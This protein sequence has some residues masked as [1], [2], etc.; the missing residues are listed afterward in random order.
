MFDTPTFQ[1]D[2]AEAARYR[3][4]SEP[5]PTLRERMASVLVKLSHRG[6]DVLAADLER[7]GFKASEI[8]AH[9]PAASVLADEQLTRDVRRDIEGYDRE[10]RIRT[11]A[12]IVRGLMPDP[13]MIYTTLRHAG[14]ETL[15]VGD[16][17]PDIIA[18]AADEFDAS[19]APR[20]GQRAA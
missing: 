12:L 19:L 9:L 1:S 6:R 15:E 14:F 20:P 8:A 3:L 10:A 2:A 5:T 18:R 16:L 13:G 7:E 4:T 17:W 11:G